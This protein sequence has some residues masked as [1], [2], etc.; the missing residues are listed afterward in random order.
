VLFKISYQDEQQ[1]KNNFHRLAEIKVEMIMLQDWDASGYGLPDNTICE[2]FEN[3]E[4][5]K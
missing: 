2:L 5:F 3:V 1:F 4:A